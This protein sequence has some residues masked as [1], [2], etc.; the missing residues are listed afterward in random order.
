MHI[1]CNTKSKAPYSQADIHA[2]TNRHTHTQHPAASWSVLYMCDAVSGRTADKLHNTTRHS[3]S[4]VP[5]KM[6]RLASSQHTAS[7]LM[8]PPPPTLSL[9][10]LFSQCGLSFRFFYYSPFFSSFC[11]LLYSFYSCHLYSQHAAQTFLSPF[12]HLAP[13]IAVSVA[14]IW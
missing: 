9:F 2:C 11:I 1:P 8:F 7:H 13:S 4:S 12:P 6:S 3:G 10:V 14:D 5:W